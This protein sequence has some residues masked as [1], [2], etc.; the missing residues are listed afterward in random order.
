M[1]DRIVYF[2]F[3]RGIA[4]I[5]VVAIHSSGVGYEYD[6]SSFNF[7]GTMAWRQF[8]N[9]SVP[10]FLTISGFFA[11]KK[12]ITNKQ[13]YYR[14][15]KIQL[16][17]VLIPF[18]IWSLL[19]SILSIKHGKPIEEILFDFFTFQSSGFFTSYY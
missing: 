6:D 11:S 1:K 13:D 2:D 4:I 8:I 7:I 17:R 18:F 10:L 15:L 12:E 16:P 14:F 3:L 19:Y 5:G 9:F